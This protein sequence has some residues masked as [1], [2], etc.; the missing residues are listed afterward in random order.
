MGMEMDGLQTV[1][2]RTGDELKWARIFSVS[3]PDYVHLRVFS[4]ARE[5]ER[6][7]K[8]FTFKS[9]M[10]GAKLRMR[11]ALTHYFGEEVG[12]RIA[13]EMEKAAA[14]GDAAAIG[15]QA[16][17]QVRNLAYG[18]SLLCR[19]DGRKSLDERLDMELAVLEWCHLVSDGGIAMDRGSVLSDDWLGCDGLITRLS[20]ELKEA[21]APELAKL[22]RALPPANPDAEHDSIDTGDVYDAEAAV[23]GSVLAFLTEGEEW[24]RTA[25]EDAAGRLSAMDLFSAQDML[26]RAIDRMQEPSSLSNWNPL[27]VMS[28]ADWDLFHSDNRPKRLAAALEVAMEEAR[29]EHGRRQEHEWQKEL[30]AQLSEIDRAYAGGERSTGC[31]M[32]RLFAALRISGDGQVHKTV[33][34]LRRKGY[35]D[36]ADARWLEGMASV[37]DARYRSSWKDVDVKAFR[38]VAGGA[39]VVDSVLAFQLSSDIASGKGDGYR[40][41]CHE[42]SARVRGQDDGKGR[43]KEG[44]VQVRT[45][46]RGGRED[47]R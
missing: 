36:D 46:S 6:A 35:L 8:L 26:K 41:A 37:A 34:R 1:G 43:P 24:V 42:L 3:R 7:G 5:E 20:P 29:S 28:G 44:H 11:E 9:N 10:E 13:E 16:S 15:R 12:G 38:E 21:A 40:G 31:Q 17:R 39:D 14:E 22:R 27:D 45:S 19:T 33:D 18:H 30:C 32:T 4:W 25:H 23:A 2:R 47:G